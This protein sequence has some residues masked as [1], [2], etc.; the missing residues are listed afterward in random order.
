MRRSL[1]RALALLL[2]LTLVAACGGDDDGGGSADDGD[3]GTT[4]QVTAPADYTEGL[5]T[6]IGDFQDDLQQQSTEFQ[7]AFGSGTPSPD[8]AKD[9][10]ASFVGDLS[11]RTQQLIDDVEALGTPDVDNGDE[12]R[13][14]LTAAF[15]RVVE[16]FDQAEADI[17]AL[18]T[19]DPAALAEGFTEVGTKLQEAG[20]DISASFDDLQSPE[21]D[22]A[23]ADVEACSGISVRRSA[24][25]PG[26]SARRR[27][28][29]A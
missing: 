22:E 13:E 25:R 8:E 21:L 23:A 26:R 7:N 9:T 27:S 24:P 5:C 16:A 20:T 15:E 4:D 6:A 19:D 3:G 1:V 17:E 10:L 18:S 12:V 14:T 29:R 2:A 11:T 28:S